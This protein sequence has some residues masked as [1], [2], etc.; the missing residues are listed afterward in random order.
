MIDIQSSAYLADKTTVESNQDIFASTEAYADTG[1]RHITN[2]AFYVRAHRNSKSRLHQSPLEF[3]CA[4]LGPRYIRIIL[5]L[6]FLPFALRKHNTESRK[7]S[8]I[9]ASVQAPLIRFSNLESLGFD[10]ATMSDKPVSSNDGPIQW[11]E[12]TSKKGRPYQTNKD[13]ASDMETGDHK[14]ALTDKH[15]FTIQVNW[16]VTDSEDWVPTSPEVQRIAGITRYRLFRNPSPD[17]QNPPLH[18]YE[19]TLSFTNTEHYDYYFTDKTNDHYRNDTYINRDHDI[20]YNSD[21][22]TIVSITGV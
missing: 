9:L 18:W 11:E 17:H 12:A 2:E 8:S 1:P 15:D 19:Y 21:D 5:A 16:P 3:T 6:V 20:Q 22:P 4:A 14:P 13:K 7:K 10:K